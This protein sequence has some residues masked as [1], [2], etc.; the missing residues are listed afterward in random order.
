MRAWFP[1]APLVAGAL[2][3]GLACSDSAP[4]APTAPDEAAAA[5][6][7]A[8]A[9]RR[10]VLATIDTLRADRV[11]SYG[12]G[13]GT[14]PHLDELAEAGTRF[15]DAISPVPLTLPTH[16]TLL[17]GLDPPAH[18]VRH[19]GRFRLTEDIPTLAD[20]FREAG[21]AT[22]AFVAAAVL[23]RRYGLERSF[24]RYD[25]QL[26]MAAAGRAAVLVPSR[27]ANEVVDAALAWLEDAPE[28]FFLWVHF[29][30]PHQEHQPPEPW[31]TRFSADLYDAEIAFADHELGRLL[32]A[33]E[34]RWPDG[35][36]AVV[37][38]SDHGESRGEHGEWT[39]A[40]TIYD[41]TQRVPLLVAGPRVQPGHVV[42][43]Q[44]ALADVAPTVLAWFDLPAFPATDG[45]DLGPALRGAAAPPDRLA[46]VETLATQFDFGWSPQ[47]G[48]RSDR[49]KY[50]RVPRP[51]L[52]DLEAD[53][54]E[55]DDVATANA[56]E[57][58]RLDAEIEARIQAGRLVEPNLRV[59]DAERLRLEALGYVEV[60]PRSGS[61]TPLGEVGGKDPKDYMHQLDALHV[62]NTRI[63]Q[64]RGEEALEALAVFGEGGEN[65]RLLRFNAAL[66]AG[67]LDLA[68][69]ALAAMEAEGSAAPSPMLGVRLLLH[70][71]RFAE[72]EARL[73]ELEES[74]AEDGNRLTLLGQALEYQGRRDDARA[75]YEVARA[76]AQPSASSLWRLAALETE[77]GELS[78]ARALL[79]ELPPG[80]LSREPAAL[81][82]AQA[83]LAAGRTQM[84]RMRLAAAEKAGAD[85]EALHVAVSE[86]LDRLERPGDALVAAERAL[87]LAPDSP[88][89]Q[90]RVA[91]LLARLGRELPRAETLARQAVAA[92]DQNLGA[93]DT[94]ALALVMEGDYAEALEWAE[95]GLARDGE[96]ADLRYRRAEALAGLGRTEE[97]RAAREQA[98]AAPLEGPEEP[99]RQ[100][101]EA[102]LLR[103]LR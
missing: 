64:G 46:W 59:D 37:A 13:A 102:R 63:A 90:N 53:P 1:L 50:L 65:V 56:T 40:F 38:T 96:R 95:G 21:F 54:D 71:G 81:R 47:L 61:G 78:R 68:E 83:E 99:L 36:T 80:H 57:A 103:L 2:L 91:W 74:H 98:R 51:E 79:A 31:A 33:I 25:D 26:G 94:L 84:A 62:A 52:Y 86:V 29:Y 43:E 101:A 70:Q 30:D 85:T 17:T 20:R 5:P 28:D 45:V 10:L 19:N 77:D 12:W 18:G 16:A 69:E 93:V 9:P 67:R 42:D 88:A 44:V 82:L 23:D 49:W 41:A 72:A 73:V 75:A 14:T 22:G 100:E 60:A 34:A 48:L 87:A 66:A 4:P 7:S 27:P 58:A 32:T 15:V 39:H 89:H 24:D 97:A 6:Y 8:D 3:A 76:A 55:L 11:G 92:T 35:A